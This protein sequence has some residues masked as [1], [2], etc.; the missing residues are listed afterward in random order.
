[1]APKVPSLLS[2]CILSPFVL[3][4]PSADRT[5]RFVHTTDESSMREI[6]AI[7]RTMAEPQQ[8]TLDPAARTISVSGP[9]NLLPLADWLLNELDKPVDPQSLGPSASKL[10]YRLKDEP[11]NLVRIF[12]LAHA[13]SPQVLNELAALLRTATWVR[14][15]FVSNGQ[16]AIVIRGTAEQIDD[17]A[18]LIERLDQPGDG[19]RKSLIYESSAQSTEKFLGLFYLNASA[20]PQALNEAAAVLRTTIDMRRLLTFNRFRV[21]VTRGG[22]DEMALASWLVD[23][24]QRPARAPGDAGPSTASYEFRPPPIDPDATA[25]RVFFLKSSMSPQELG[26]FAMKLRRETLIRRLLAY[27]T[28][29]SLVLRGTPVQIAKAEQIIKESIR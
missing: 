20:T 14:R 1:M 2:M 8:A 25:I 5:F 9:E 22:A 13:E 29:M 7:V 19:P 23:Q 6:A 15:L 17:A 27:S 26:E 21:I 11:E 3:A 18:W 28:N 4:Q 10:E 16:K 12:H 24:L